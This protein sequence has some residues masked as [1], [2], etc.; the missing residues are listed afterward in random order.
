MGFQSFQMLY[1]EKVKDNHC[2][3]KLETTTKTNTECKQS[4]KN[5]N[6]F[7]ETWEN[8]DSTVLIPKGVL[9]RVRVSYSR[10]QESQGPK[11]CDGV[12]GKV[13]KDLFLMIGALWSIVTK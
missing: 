8:T 6:E 10:F 3:G 13:A 5:S 4:C 7:Q 1:K 9:C 12:Y 11:K 2:M